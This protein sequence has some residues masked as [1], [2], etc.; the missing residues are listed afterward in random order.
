MSVRGVTAAA[1]AARADSLVCTAGRAAA[2]PRA[3]LALGQG[4]VLLL[5]AEAAELWNTLP[6]I[7]GPDIKKRDR[8]FAPAGVE[9][10]DACPLDW[11]AAAAAE[12]R[13]WLVAAAD[14]D[15]LVRAFA[16]DGAVS[17]TPSSPPLKLP[18]KV[19]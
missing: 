2:R 11:G 10:C 7:E 12:R 5:S 3:A 17:D 1:R 14:M 15:Q 19:Q 16:R 18:G 13:H 8:R 9:L 4:R 6:R